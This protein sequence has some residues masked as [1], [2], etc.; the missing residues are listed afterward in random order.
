MYKNWFTA[1]EITEE[2][3]ALNVTKKLKSKKRIQEIL[4][5]IEKKEKNN[6]LFKTRN[7]NLN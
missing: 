4:K 3:N 6:E 7:V 2:I 5:K 1:D